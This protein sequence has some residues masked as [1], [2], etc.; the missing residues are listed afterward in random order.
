MDG[1][2]SKHDLFVYIRKT[3]RASAAIYEHMLV[4]GALVE[5]WLYE[6]RDD[7]LIAYA[8]GEWYARVVG[9]RLAKRPRAKKLH[10]KQL[11]MFE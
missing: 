9:G 10:P 3:P 2:K 4:G 11:K 6:L 1:G 8:N 7:E 5:Q